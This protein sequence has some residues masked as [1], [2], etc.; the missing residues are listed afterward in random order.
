[1]LSY[2]TVFVDSPNHI[3][4]AKFSIAQQEVIVGM[5]KGLDDNKH[6]QCDVQLVIKYATLTTA[7]S[8]HSASLVRGVARALGVRHK[9]VMGT[10][11]WKMLM[12]ANGFS[13]WSFS[14]RKKKD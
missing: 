6:V 5:A 13:L 10:I 9:N 12:D 4:L 3:L 14:M 2:V 8:A 7:I 1:M 11:S